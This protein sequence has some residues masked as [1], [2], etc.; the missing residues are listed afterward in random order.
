ML[1]MTR[2]GSTIA[3]TPCAT[4]IQSHARPA[5]PSSDSRPHSVW[6]EQCPIGFEGPVTRVAKCRNFGLLSAFARQN[7]VGQQSSAQG[8]EN[9]WTAGVIEF[10][11]R[12]CMS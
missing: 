10:G 7:T 4:S 3:T 9:T 12:V 2:M 6:P 8:G 11:N 5:S 1:V